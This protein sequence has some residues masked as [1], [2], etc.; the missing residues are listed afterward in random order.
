MGPFWK[1]RKV[2]TF[3]IYLK[4]FFRIKLH[5]LKKYTVISEKVDYN[6]F[7]SVLSSHL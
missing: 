3:A 7:V 5:S 2:K 4:A 1:D 6:F